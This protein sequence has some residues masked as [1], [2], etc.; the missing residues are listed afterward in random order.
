MRLWY[1]GT[2]CTN[3]YGRPLAGTDDLHAG[4][5]DFVVEHFLA[6]HHNGQLVPHVSHDIVNV[7][8]SHVTPLSQ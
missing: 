6:A 2:H 7:Y 4:L 8:Y 3:R 1:S 5:G